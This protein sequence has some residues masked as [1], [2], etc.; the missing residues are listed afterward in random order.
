[1]KNFIKNIISVPLKWDTNVQTMNV[2]ALTYHKVATTV[3][4]PPTH[5]C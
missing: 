2:Y 3:A 5:I 4:S 1:M